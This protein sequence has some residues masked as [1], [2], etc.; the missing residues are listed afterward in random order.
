MT[1]QKPEALAQECAD[2]ATS[3]RSAINV[4]KLEGRTAPISFLRAAELFE[5]AAAR[6]AELEAQLAA[7][8]SQAQPVGAAPV[9]PD[10]DP[11]T[12][13]QYRRMF[14]AACEALGA[15]SEELGLDPDEGGAD[16]ILE[17]IHELRSGSAQ[18]AAQALESEARKQDEALIRKML[19]ALEALEQA[20]P[21][22]RGLSLV[23][24]TAK[25]LTESHD[26]AI[27]AARRQLGGQP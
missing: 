18:P 13:A 15:I 4:V 21:E 27:A 14:Q 25:A 26:R 16:P 3:L 19:E 17:A 2:Y 23:S 8:A 9:T 5:R 22:L 20:L 10:D 1:T 6:I 12:K 11:T 7:L 24:P